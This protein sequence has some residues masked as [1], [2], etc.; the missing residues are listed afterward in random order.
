[1]IKSTDKS[2]IKKNCNIPI[3]KKGIVHFDFILTLNGNLQ[4][5]TSTKIQIQF[6]TKMK[7][8]SCMKNGVSVHE[9]TNSNVLISCR[10]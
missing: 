3:K 5:N 10:I 7:D 1:M 6:Q 8:V 9:H 2:F 4:K